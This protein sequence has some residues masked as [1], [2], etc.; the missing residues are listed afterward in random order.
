MELFKKL[1]PEAKIPTRAT[2]K[3]AGMD[4]HTVEEVYIAPM[5][6][7][8]LSTGIALN[9]LDEGFYIR[10]APKSGL[11]FKH[12]IDVLAGVVD[13]DYTGEIG[14]G[15]INLGTETVHFKV[16]QSIA[17]LIIEAYGVH[18]SEQLVTEERGAGGFGS[19]GDGL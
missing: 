18:A 5:G 13:C 4:I 6:R 14:V 11:A 17:Q 3:S 9:N 19:T 8:F 15:L 10:I 7:L 12:G 2:V 16:G 1:V